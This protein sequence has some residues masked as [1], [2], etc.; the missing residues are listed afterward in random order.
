MVVAPSSPSIQLGWKSLDFFNCMTLSDDQMIACIEKYAYSANE[1]F[2]AN[3][4]HKFNPIYFN[5]K[6]VGLFSA[7]SN[8]SIKI[9]SYYFHEVNGMANTLEVES[10]IMSQTFNARR[11]LVDQ[12]STLQ[13]FLNNSISY[14][15]QF[16]D[17]KLMIASMRPD[18]VPRLYIHL[19]PGAQ[20]RFMFI[21]V[22][23]TNW[24]L[25][26]TSKSYLGNKT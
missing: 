26:N 13:L 16:T 15:V 4:N 8:Q 5:N 1:I 24:C 3:E 23:F 22:C 9:K 11:G 10:G 6:I 7:S 17:P 20:N 14:Y 19:K 21:K 18:T 25:L 12:D 2:I